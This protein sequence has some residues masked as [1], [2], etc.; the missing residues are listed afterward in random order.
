MKVLSHCY[1]LNDE[2]KEKDKNMDFEK[3][4]FEIEMSET[5]QVQKMLFESIKHFQN[6]QEIKELLANNSIY[7]EPF[8][9]ECKQ[10]TYYPFKN[11]IKQKING[12]NVS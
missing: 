5:R 8:I 2:K 10:A 3:S 1:P 6:V 11:Q 9:Q 12:L 7:I 4:D